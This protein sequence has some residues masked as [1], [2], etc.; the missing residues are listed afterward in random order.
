MDQKYLYVNY[1]NQCSITLTRVLFDVVPFLKPLK[2]TIVKFEVRADF[3]SGIFSE[4]NSHFLD[5]I[6][7]N[8]ATLSNRTIGDEPKIKFLF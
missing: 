7:M 6:T 1:Q 5:N 3:K 8:I 4:L 2:P